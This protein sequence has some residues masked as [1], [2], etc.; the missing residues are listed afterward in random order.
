ML[1]GPARPAAKVGGIHDNSCCLMMTCNKYQVYRKGQ[2]KS[3]Y[4][5]ITMTTSAT[6]PPP[7]H[8]DLEEHRPHRE[9]K[10]KRRE[11]KLTQLG[12]VWEQK[13]KHKVREMQQLLE[14]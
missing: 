12:S 3:H 5:Q 6:Q 2:Q 4:M 10:K 9:R 8:G 13:Q 11:E 7:Q 14:G 1:V